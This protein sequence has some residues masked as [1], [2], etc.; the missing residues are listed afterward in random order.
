MHK[1]KL[2]IAGLCTSFFAS[3]FM[4]NSL[5]TTDTIP[6]ANTLINKINISTTS[7]INN[8]TEENGFITKVEYKNKQFSPG[9]VTIRKGNYIEI[10]NTNKD[11]QMWL[12]SSAPELSTVRGLGEGEVVKIVMENIG[13]YQ[14]TN[15]LFTQ[16]SFTVKVIGE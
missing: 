4:I 13:E 12:Q 16:A 5:M 10:K 14:I 1:K 15:K 7:F 2:A 11:E 8:K 9:S 3:G 6:F